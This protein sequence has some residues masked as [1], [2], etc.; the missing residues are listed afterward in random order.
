MSSAE[1]VRT[2]N[3]TQCPK[4]IGPK[5][6][7]II[8]WAIF[9]GSITA[10]YRMGKKNRIIGLTALMAAVLEGLNITFTDVPGG[11]VKKIS[12]PSHGRIALGN[13]PTFGVLPLFMGFPKRPESLFF[14]SHVALGLLL[15]AMTDF[16]AETK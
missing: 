3:F 1:E 7:A 16:N 5:T 10:A 13:L 14:Y 11:L 12:F 4:V 9:A 8:D 6:H 15:I 2:F